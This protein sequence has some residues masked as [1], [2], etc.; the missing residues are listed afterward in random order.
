MHD[1][2]RPA[3]STQYASLVLYADEAQREAAQA[4][5]EATAIRFGRPALTRVEPLNS[6]HL[7]EDY[8]QKYALR[9]DDILSAG[10]RSRYSGEDA[11]RESTLAA[12]LNGFAYGVGDAALLD[13]EIASY[14]LPAVAESHLRALV[15]GS[16]RE[17]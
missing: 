11:F 6:F 15:R 10:I 7:A 8:H 17:A 16:A 2:S 4:A 5:L 13:R 12:R 1:P 9:S 3:H 14:E